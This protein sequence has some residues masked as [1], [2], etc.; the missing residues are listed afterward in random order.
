MRKQ[1]HYTIMSPMLIY[2][3]LISGILGLFFIGY[4]PAYFLLPGRGNPTAKNNSI[5]EK[6]YI[7]FISFYI[8]ALITSLFFIIMSLAGIKYDIWP[9]LSLTLAGLEVFPATFGVELNGPVS[10]KTSGGNL[11]IE[12]SFSAGGSIRAFF[13]GI[14]FKGTDP[15]HAYLDRNTGDQTIYAKMGVLESTGNITKIY[16]GDLNIGTRDGVILSGDATQYLQG[17]SG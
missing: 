12:D 9:I 16:D 8:G 5:S 17:K 2:L 14:A 4:L 1:Q 10:V 3:K 13:G 7:F 6:L 15:V 11:T